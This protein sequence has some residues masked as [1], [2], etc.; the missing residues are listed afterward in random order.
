MKR[1]PAL[2]AVLLLAAPV[3]A[4]CYSGFGATTTYQAGL[5]SGN[6]VEARVGQIDIENTTVVLGPEGSGTATLLVRLVNVG[7]EEDSLVYATINGQSAYFTPDPACVALGANASVAYGNV[8]GDCWIN[9]YTFDAPVSTYVPVELGFEKAGLKKISVLTVPP[10][11]YYEG[12]APNP[13]TAP[14]G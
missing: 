11:G 10:A 9:S 14:V 1:T 4:G 13:A 6:G 2:L 7:V 3:L 12:I 8:D 5:N